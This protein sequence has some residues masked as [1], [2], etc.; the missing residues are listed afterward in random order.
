VGM[1]QIDER[2]AS[3]YF[4]CVSGPR[5]RGFDGE[6]Q[7]AGRRSQVAGRRV[8]R[9]VSAR[10]GYCLVVPMS[11]R[12]HPTGVIMPCHHAMPCHSS[13]EV[14]RSLGGCMQ[15]CRHADRQTGRQADRQTCR[16]ADMQTCSHADMQTPC[17]HTSAHSLP[18]CLVLCP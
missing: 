13:S 18:L 8:E 9:I 6:S 1:T 2:Y 17:H 7:V 12:I 11:S 3:V 14:R 5:G 15:T 10:Q 4:L 16:H